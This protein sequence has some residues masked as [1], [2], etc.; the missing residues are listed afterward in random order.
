MPTY[1]L[2]LFAENFQFYLQDEST[3]SD[4]S[5]SWT[6]AAVDN[7]LALAP[8]AIGVGTVRDMTVPVTVEVREERP[9]ESEIWD[10]IN[11]CTI[12]IP[13][14]KLVVAGSG[15]YLPDAKR[16]P[17][18]PGKYNA[19]ILYGNLGTVSPDGQDGEDQYKIVLWPQ[20]R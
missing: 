1:S 18:T 10:K 8:G 2:N 17:V 5:H 7:L 3:Q 20:A 12:E 9:I 4:L 15:D 16:I 19:R 13:S 11:E 14:G 6:Q